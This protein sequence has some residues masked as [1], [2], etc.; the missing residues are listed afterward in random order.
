[1]ERTPAIE[2]IPTIR[3]AIA[4]LDAEPESPLASGRRAALWRAQH[5]AANPRHTVE[6][7]RRFCLDSLAPRRLVEEGE[8][9]QGY[10]AGFQSLLE[11]IRDFEAGESS[12]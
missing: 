6:D 9:L 3:E 11:R 7:L 4:G 10:R 1:M 12:R 2:L 8:Y 5:H